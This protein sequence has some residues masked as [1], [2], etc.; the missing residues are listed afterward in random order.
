MKYF[1]KINKINQIIVSD[2]SYDEDVSCRYEKTKLNL[3]DW[4]VTIDIKESSIT[5]QGITVN[6]IDF[7]ILLNKPSVN[8]NFTKDGDFSYPSDNKI[9]EFDIGMDTACVS[10]GINKYTDYIRGDRDTWQ[11]DSAL[12]TLTD[13]LFGYVYE[14]TNKATNE[15]SFIYISGYL[16]EDT[17]YSIE[18]IIDYIS[19]SFEI[20]ELTKEKDV[21]CIGGIEIPVINKDIDYDI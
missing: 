3:T 17:G 5:E 6:G 18:D 7:I 14:G 21:K 13:G 10:L 9:K 15:M 2:P 8:C 19:D 16:D 12:K 20:K 1:G 4:D 11:S